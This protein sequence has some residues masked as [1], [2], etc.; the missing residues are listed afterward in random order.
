MF[1]MFRHLW[2][3]HRVMRSPLRTSTT[4][5]RGRQALA[6]AVSVIVAVAAVGSADQAGAQDVGSQRA[7]VARIAKELD[8][9]EMQVS[10]LDERYLSLKGEI[11]A[12]KRQQSA[13][14]AEVASARTR[15]TKARTQAGSYV[16]TAFIGAGSDAKTALGSGDPNQSVNQKVL[17][18]VLRGDRTQLADD[19]GA[20]EAD[21]AE[22]R[23]KLDRTDARLTAKQSRLSKLRTTVEST[24]AQQEQLLAGANADL[25]AAIAAEQ[26][27]MAIA[28]QQQA[29]ARLAAARSAARP[30]TRTVTRRV[31]VRTATGERRTVVR[32][33]P[34]AAPAPATGGGDATAPSPP[35]ADLPVSAPSGR[36]GSVLS[37]GRSVFGTRYRWGGTSTATGF[38]CS[39]FT[40]Y[41]WR[42]AGVN[43]PHSSR[44]QYAA[45]QRVGAGQ[46]QPGDLVFYGRPIHHVAIYIGN[47]QVMH[48][49][50]TGDVVRT[51]PLR[52]P[53]GYGRPG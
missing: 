35:P 9:L 21:L 32:R 11:A 44:A 41:A 1:V 26:E 28:A 43:L 18:E 13:N 50:H 4:R 19:L 49:P 8:R 40:S 7:K 38:D 15:L 12:L 47:G 33:V 52:N 10:V 51:G 25:R 14:A 37:T 22:S 46:L 27:R 17:L 42:A 36:V 5:R 20:R 31:T 48:S 6:A 45:T 39:G 29:A 3:T 2:L 16:V 30:T 24:V 53:S 34:V 23:R